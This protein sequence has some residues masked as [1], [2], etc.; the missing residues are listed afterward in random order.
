MHATILEASSEFFKSALKTGWRK[1]EQDVDLR[2]QS[3]ES[4]N[5]YVHWLYYN[6]I[7]TETWSYHADD[8][9]CKTPDFIPLARLYVLGEHLN[10]T[11][12]QD[13]VIS[14]IVVLTQE[15]D[16]DG[17]HWYPGMDAI[18]IIYDGTTAESPA[19]RLVVDFHVRHGT[20]NWIKDHCVEGD[21]ENFH[22]DF[23]I[24]LSQALLKDRVLLRKHEK[25]YT[26]FAT[27]TPCNYHNHD[28]DKPCAA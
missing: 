1:D 28:K 26:Q 14:A 5:S 24:D 19:R 4:F 3:T 23:L 17:I 15:K 13:A 18:N 6:Q 27:R 25:N 7:I 2:D 9:K 11:R 22:H 16:Q 20:E 21:P 8:D 10:D 12:F